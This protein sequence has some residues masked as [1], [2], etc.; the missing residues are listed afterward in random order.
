MC[1]TLTVPYFFKCILGVVVYCVRGFSFSNFQM[2]NAIYNC[3]Y[4]I[5]SQLQ[6][7]H[8]SE[9]NCAT[10]GH[11]SSGGTQWEKGDL[12]DV[13]LPQSLSRAHIHS[14]LLRQLLQLYFHFQKINFICVLQKWNLCVT[15]PVA[16]F[17]KT[18]QIS[19]LLT[20][21]ISHHLDIFLCVYH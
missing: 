9:F 15:Q 2:D 7:L 16:I 5:L 6:C 4:K 3:Q 12:S 13:R 19:K 21:L 11:W 1:S 8:I 10:A 14:W 17:A 20:H 18:K